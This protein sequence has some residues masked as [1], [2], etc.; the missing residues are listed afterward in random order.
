VNSVTVIEFLSVESVLLKLGVALLK[1]VVAEAD[2]A[3]FSCWRSLKLVASTH[4]FKAT[5]TGMRQSSPSSAVPLLG[6]PFKVDE[7]HDV[8]P[9][10]PTSLSSESMIFDGSGPHSSIMLSRCISFP[11]PPPFMYR[12]SYD[13]M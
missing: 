6:G 4:T 5:S 13:P 10:G 2:V 8:I 11:D 3:L 9:P 7:K 1:L 12:Y